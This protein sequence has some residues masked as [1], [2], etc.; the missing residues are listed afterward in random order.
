[1]WIAVVAAQALL[2]STAAAQGSDS[3][4]SA[5]AFIRLDELRAPYAGKIEARIGGSRESVNDKLR[6]DIGASVPIVG[7]DLERDTEGRTVSGLTFGAD[8][9]TW[10]RLR[11]SG[12]FKFPVEAVDYHFGVRG[13]WFE[14]G[15][16]RPGAEAR[17]RIA[18]ISAHIVDGDPSFTDPEQ[19]Y[20]TYSREFID[21][22]GGYR[23]PLGG[24]DASSRGTMRTYLGGIWLF[25]TIPDTLG[26]LTPYGGFDAAWEPWKDRPFTLR[27]GYELR[28]SSELETVAE[29][30]ARIGL[31]FG[32]IDSRG[33][34]VEAAYYAGRSPYGQH[35]FR[36]EEYYSLG[37]SVDL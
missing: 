26:T 33:V 13:D 36:K 11:S 29:H 24:D 37:F 3:A 15:D 5:R 14:N 2:V 4:G 25:N 16:D 20:F 31:K 8:F 17:L 27:A 28:I 35:F 6:L 23:T 19:R 1:M 30:Q 12:N 22:L 7:F 34:T 10:T 32:H 21:L 18:H 9:F